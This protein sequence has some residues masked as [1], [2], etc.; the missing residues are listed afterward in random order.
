MS[1]F[2]FFLGYSNFIRFC[3]YLF[4]SSYI[5]LHR[6]NIALTIYIECNC[7]IVFSVIVCSL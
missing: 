1:F 3:F 7:Y 6:C 5:T 4:K 2:P